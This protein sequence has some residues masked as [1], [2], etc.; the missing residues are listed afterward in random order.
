MFCSFT[1][2]N[3]TPKDLLGAKEINSNLQETHTVAT[4]YHD[5]HLKFLTQELHSWGADRSAQGQWKS[6]D[7]VLPASICTKKEEQLHT[8]AYR[9]C[10]EESWSSRSAHHKLSRTQEGQAHARD[11][12]TN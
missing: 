8:S 1:F 9:S 4:W 12:K 7:R 10:A 5:E 3:V 11:C 6:W 2:R